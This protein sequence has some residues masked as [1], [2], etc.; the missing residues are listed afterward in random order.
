[1]HRTLLIAGILAGL[2]SKQANA[3]DGDLAGVL[4]RNGCLG[5]KITSIYHSDSTSVFQANCGGTSHRILDVE[6][7]TAG[8]R[9]LHRGDDYGEAE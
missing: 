8:C 2:A 4:T 3:G 5:A 1:M 9:L 6:C 7:G